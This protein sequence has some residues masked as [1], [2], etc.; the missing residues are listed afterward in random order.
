MTSIDVALAVQTLC[1]VSWC[2][3]CRSGGVTWAVVALAGQVVSM[4]KEPQLAVFYSPPKHDLQLNYD[5]EMKQEDEDEN[6]A[7]WPDIGMT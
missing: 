1:D 5:E 7:Q 4:L 2:C 6:P 3:A